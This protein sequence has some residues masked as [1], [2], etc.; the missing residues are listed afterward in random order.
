MKKRYVAS[1]EEPL[2]LCAY[3][4]SPSEAFKNMAKLLK[5]EKVDWFSA[6]SV[7]VLDSD[8]DAFAVTVYV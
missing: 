3:G 2:V 4:D 1:A 8:V 5:E 7:N 6:S